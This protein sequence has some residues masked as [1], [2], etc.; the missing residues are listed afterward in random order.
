MPRRVRAG[1]RPG[2]S[3]VG[4]G[5]GPA[6]GSPAHQAAT[7]SARRIGGIKRITRFAAFAAFAAFARATGTVLGATAL[8]VAAEKVP[9]RACG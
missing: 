4:A 1:E 6:A 5:T 3:D 2:P 7:V 8:A 9:R